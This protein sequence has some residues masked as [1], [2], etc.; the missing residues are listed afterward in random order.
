MKNKPLQNALRVKN[1][2]VTIIYVHTLHDHL[3]P[4]RNTIQGSLTIIADLQVIIIIIII[5]VIEGIDRG[6][7][8]D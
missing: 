3:I 1:E 4:T 7:G 8:R 2:I 5:L 6:R